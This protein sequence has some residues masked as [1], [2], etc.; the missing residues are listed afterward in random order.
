MDLQ[1]DVSKIEG[2]ITVVRVSGQMTFKEAN[3]LESSIHA[4][5][6]QGEPKIIV[7]LIGVEQLDNVG[8]LSLVRSFFAAREVP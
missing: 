3:A 2:D 6:D 4:L 1:I 7:D 5:L 8:G